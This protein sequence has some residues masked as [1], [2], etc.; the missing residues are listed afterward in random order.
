MDFKQQIENYRPCCA[1]EEKDKEV[2]LQF[3][4]T[5]KDVLS[6]ENELGHFTCSA[7]VVNKERTKA[8]MV[9]HNIYNAWT[10]TGGHAD[11][12]DNF[13]E[14]AIREVKEETGLKSV[15]PISH[16]IFTL[17]TIAVRGHFKSGKYVSSHVHMNVTYL[18]EADEDEELCI[19][20]DENKGVMWI[21][22]NNVDKVSNEKYM[23]KIY[24][25]IMRKMKSLD[26]T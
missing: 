24:D 4:K 10:W 11:G 5:F 12:D 19:K 7:W 23:I 17:E 26:N 20:P 8:L 13:K 14:V 2:M 3:I 18:L 1:Q 16:E 6:R 9:F 21:Y 25:K 15:V 22:M